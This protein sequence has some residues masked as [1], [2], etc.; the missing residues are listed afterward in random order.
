YPRPQ[1]ATPTYRF[2][3][4]CAA[5]PRLTDLGQALEHP[6][7]PSGTALGEVDEE[8]ERR[9]AQLGTDLLRDREQEGD[10]EPVVALR[11]QRRSDAPHLRFRSVSDRPSPSAPAFDRESPPARLDRLAPAVD[12]AAVRDAVVEVPVAL[13]GEDGSVLPVVEHEPCRMFL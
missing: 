13:D 12:D 10:P 6:G 4:G 5:R 1:H 8:A 3:P 2:L 9:Q 11:R 7:T